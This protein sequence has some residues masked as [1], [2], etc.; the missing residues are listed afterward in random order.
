MPWWIVPALFLVALAVASIRTARGARGARPFAAT[1]T[2][3]RALYSR[4]RFLR[5]GCATAVS[6][7]LAYSGADVLVDD[8]HRKKVKGRASDGLATYLHQYG[9]RF[10]FAYWAAFALVD[11]F[12]VSTPLSRWG[13][14]NFEA[15][16]TGLPMLWGTQ[17]LLGAA[18]PRDAT[19][20]PRLLPLADDNSASGHAFI[21]SIPL[22]MGARSIEQPVARLA[23]LALLPWVGW[24]RINDRK[25]YL[26]QVLLGWWIGSESVDAVREPEE[27]P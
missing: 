15:M 23:I 5:L 11:S 26:G 27:A 19:H 9:E 16:L 3:Y 17:R 20:G 8:W 12:L 4:R 7:V 2:H 18:R 25:H 10:W 1:A 21:S 14:R 6:A 13:R 24:S 22:W